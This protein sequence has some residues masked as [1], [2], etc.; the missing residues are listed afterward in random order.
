MTI[1]TLPAVLAIAAIAAA[2]SFAATGVNAAPAGKP[3]IA[4]NLATNVHFYGGRSSV[5]LVCYR[6]WN[7]RWWV[8]RCIPQFYGY[9][10]KKPTYGYYNKK[11]TYG[12]YNKKPTYGYY[13]NNKYSWR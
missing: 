3:P 8:Q 6:S 1:R 4:A 10:N 7:G 12:Y 2:G 11:P 13:N 9:Y 5:R